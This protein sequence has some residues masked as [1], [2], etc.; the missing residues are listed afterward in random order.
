[1]NCV[2]ERNASLQSKCSSAQ[3]LFLGGELVNSFLQMVVLGVQFFD[4]GLAFPELQE[5]A[6]ETTVRF[7]SHDFG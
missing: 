3:L 1:M 7:M 5:K 2:V 4:F 6:R